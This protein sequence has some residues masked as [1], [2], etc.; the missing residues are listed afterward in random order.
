ME[1][2]CITVEIQIHLRYQ[3]ILASM[4]NIDTR[5]NI[6]KMQIVFC[7]QV[8]TLMSIHSLSHTYTNFMVLVDNLKLIFKVVFELLG[9][10]GLHA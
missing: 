2:S 3:L 9:K 1:I 5:Q 4:I 10:A 7:F 6:R 8:N